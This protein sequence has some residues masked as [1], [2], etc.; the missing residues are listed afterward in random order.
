M[1]GVV[2]SIFYELSRGQVVGGQVVGGQVAVVPLMLD[3]F[4][5]IRACTAFLTRPC[6]PNI[7]IGTN[8][9][10]ENGDHSIGPWSVDVCKLRNLILKSRTS[11]RI[12]C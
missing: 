10:R 11:S 4:L 5:R 3:A 6:L 1:V 9:L 12:V 7:W 2:S 8:Q